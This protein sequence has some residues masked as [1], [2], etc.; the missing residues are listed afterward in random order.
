MSG[1]ISIVGAMTF[2]IEDEMDRVCCFMMIDL[3]L[4]RTF[5]F[6]VL[7]SSFAERVLYH[8]RRK[9]TRFYQNAETAV[10]F[11][12]NGRDCVRIAPFVLHLHLY[13]LNVLRSCSLL[14]QLLLLDRGR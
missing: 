12:H 6:I 3:T 1:E 8:V 7:L 11:N 13:V 5:G 9:R 10:V 4:M 2:R 14:L